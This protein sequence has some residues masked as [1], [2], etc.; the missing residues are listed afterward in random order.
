MQC[1]PTT[2]TLTIRGLPLGSGAPA[3]GSMLRFGD[4]AMITTL[5]SSSSAGYNHPF[6]S[7]N[8]A[9][10]FDK[11]STGGMYVCVCVCVCV[12]AR[13]CW[14]LFAV[15]ILLCP[16]RQSHVH[17]LF[18]ASCP[19][20]PSNSLCGVYTSPC[21]AYM[22]ATTSF[23]YIESFTFSGTSSGSF[24]K[25]FKSY[26]GACSGIVLQQWLL[27]GVYELTGASNCGGTCTVRAG[28][29]LIQKPCLSFS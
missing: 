28:L 12:C 17:T 21:G 26:S 11:S 27:T 10:L 1:P 5:S 19:S 18:A 8:Q 6:D 2:C 15:D 24:T 3:F 16:Q 23:N 9:M 25:I 13:I 14:Y 22:D 4:Y 29:S 20:S 7:L